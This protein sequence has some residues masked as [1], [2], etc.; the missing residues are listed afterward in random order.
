MIEASIKGVIICNSE[1]GRLNCYNLMKKKSAAY[2]K[3]EKPISKI[4]PYFPNS[5]N[6]LTPHL[7]PQTI[8]KNV[9]KNTREAAIIGTI[10]FLL[11][12]RQKSLTYLTNRNPA[13]TKHDTV[14][15]NG[16]AANPIVRIHASATIIFTASP[17]TELTNGSLLF[18]KWEA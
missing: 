4:Y 6:S 15:E 16:K 9:H 2:I 5:K 1:A 12:S 13:V 3:N 17:I 18:R 14:V 8:I 10:I 7:I 11:S